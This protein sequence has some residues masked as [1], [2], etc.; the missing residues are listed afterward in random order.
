MLQN[1]GYAGNILCVDLSTGAVTNLSK[2]DYSTRFLGGRGIAAKIYWD[3]VSPQ[4]GSFDPDNCLLFFTG[5]LAGFPALAGSRW[6]VCGKSPIA[7]PEG[8][9][10][11]NLGGH[12]GAH[13]K[14]AGYD[15]VVIKGKSDKPVY[16]SIQDETVQIRDASY[17]W[18]KG[19]AQTREELKAELGKSVKVV[20]IGPA[21]EHL[22]PL[23]ILLADNDASGSGG[24]GAV[25]GSKNLKA[26][27][28]A[29]SGSVRAANPDRLGEVT[30]H[31]RQVRKGYPR[32]IFPQS[33]PSKMKWDF[34]YGCIWGCGRAIFE[35]EDGAKGKL[36]CGSGVFYEGRARKYYG[37]YNSAVS[38]RA[39][40][41]C[42]D[43]GLDTEAIDGIMMWLSRCFRA[44]ILSDDNTGIPLSKMGSLE[45]IETL[46][47]K[48]ALR[49][50]F[51]D[52][53]SQG[54]V[55]AAQI[56]GQG[57]QE[58]IGDII[59]KG[60]HVSSHDPR[61]YITNA[62]LY[63]TEPRMPIQQIHEVGLLIVR[64]LGWLGKQ[65]GRDHFS[66]SLVRAIGKKFWGGEIA[67]DFSN[68]EGKALAA[69]KIQDRQYVK[70]SLIT[71]DFYW[72]MT[73]YENTEDHLGDPTLESQVYSAVTGRE[74]DEEQLYH[75]GERIVNLQRAI[76]VREG[77][78]GRK[79]DR[80]PEAYF[81]V[82]LR[83]FLGNPECLVPG[84]GGEVISR[85]G[86]VV[87]RDRFEEMK[88]EYYQLRDWDVDSGLQPEEKLKELGLSDIAAELKKG[89]LLA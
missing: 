44:G 28:V 55:K 51:G 85:K 69:K 76:L 16:L 25:M 60:G 39:T 58:L 2:S 8:F 77:H 15:G 71:C 67:A 72:P 6:M 38:F 57:T 7:E 33:P 9:S 32:I 52:V 64:W 88:S 10:Y 26:I 4:T 56:V 13:L 18:G 63:A 1:D 3:E 30:R 80:L 31:I 65:E 17:L 43:Y 12:W 68:Y 59:S 41:L 82:P 79:D 29:G 23:S 70:E 50:G 62:M 89:G 74:V 73:D 11:C 34:C 87:D 37:G 75:V 45:Y 48:I 20:A 66:T 53:L 81:T 86:A 40:R 47:R 84:V 21:G 54:T 36:L 19:A 49:E 83:T 5:P 22:V 35:T 61:L 24:F 42:D 78:Q 14:F 46:V 27:V